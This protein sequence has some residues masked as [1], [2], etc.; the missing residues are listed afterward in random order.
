MPPE[1]LDY[2]AHQA[3]LGE[4]NLYL[5]YGS[6]DPFLTPDRL[7]SVEEIEQKHQ[8]DFDERTFEGGHEILPD[9]LLTFIKNMN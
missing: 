8:V 6:H 5:L 1:D 3:Y 7:S 4:K 9:T 2:A